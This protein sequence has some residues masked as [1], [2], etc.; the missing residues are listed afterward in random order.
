MKA[1][2]KEIKR[3]E[4]NLVSKLDVKNLKN[5]RDKEPEIV[6]AIRDLIEVGFDEAGIGRLIRRKNPQMWIESK[7]AESVARALIAEGA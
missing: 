6:D 1:K 5:L 3:R 4:D 7:F 2:P